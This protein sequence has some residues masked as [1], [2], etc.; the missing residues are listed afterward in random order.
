MIKKFLF[1][2]ILSVMMIS[3]LSGCGK[4]DDKSES[5]KNNTESG[6]DI[7]LFK[8]KDDKKETLI[9]ED[10]EDTILDDFRT[11]PNTPEE[12]AYVAYEE[13]LNDGS[14]GEI[15]SYEFVYIDDDDIPELVMV[16]GNG[17]L[18][19][20]YY[21]GKV[22]QLCYS[23]ATFFDYVERQGYFRY[24]GMY[25]E[26]YYG[27]LSSGQVEVVAYYNPV[28]DTD[29]N[30]TDK[31]TYYLGSIENS[32]E[33][34][35]D[36]Y[37]SYISSLGD[38]SSLLSEGIKYS[39]MDDAYKALTGMSYNATTNEEQTYADT[40]G[41]HSINTS[42]LCDRE[43]RD[44]F[45]LHLGCYVDYAL[46]NEKTEPVNI[47]GMLKHTGVVG[48]ISL[49]NGMR[50]VSDYNDS[51]FSMQ[52]QGTDLKMKVKYEES[53]NYSCSVEILEANIN[54]DFRYKEGTDAQIGIVA[55]IT[56]YIDGEKV[57]ISNPYVSVI[58]E[59]SSSSPSEWLMYSVV[60]LS[61]ND[62]SK[63]Q[64]NCFTGYLED[65]Y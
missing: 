53:V 23:S 13:Y 3:S 26:D 24:G 38:F 9:K 20:S 29:G 31:K 41:G 21:N 28:R 42:T 7:D 55:K 11:E 4:T 25:R 35:Q 16:P 44:F 65:E 30:Y 39:S 2:V 19:L 36:E 10:A 17:C 63:V 59:N 15:T 22:V 61:Q 14:Y 8:N 58:L 27:K 49:D 64:G 52:L 45:Q 43:L 12:L 34:T 60:F 32:K 18:A 37:D 1:G 5:Y 56:Y 47:S 54:G 33:V 57:Q 50:V 40:Q 51:L 48:A 62:Y 46:G 6:A